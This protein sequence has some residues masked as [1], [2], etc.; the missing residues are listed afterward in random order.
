MA[1]GVIDD[2]IFFALSDGINS[3]TVWPIGVGEASGAMR[4]VQ[5]S[6]ASNS[7]NVTNA[8]IS[9]TQSGGWTV[10]SALDTTQGFHNADNRIKVS[11]ETGGSGLTDAELRATPVPIS[12][13]SSLLVSQLSGAVDSV[14]ITN[15]SIPVTGTFWQSTQPVSV[16]DTLVINQ[17]SGS[18]WSVSAS[19]DTTASLYNAD[20]R[21]RVSLEP[22]GSG[23]TDAE[24]RASPVPVMQVSGYSDSV[25]ITNASI[26]VTGTFWQT[27]QPISAGSSLTVDQLSGAN[28]SV[29]A[30]LVASSSINVNGA[31]NSTVSVGPV[32][33]DAVDDGAA[34]QKVGGTA[35]T[36]NPTAVAGGDIVRFVGDKIGRQLSRPVQ[37]REL[38]KTAYA[39]LT[40]GAET[41]LLAGTAGEFNDL[42]W[43]SFTNL[44]TAAVAL[45]T[46]A[47]VDIRSTTAGPVV[48]SAY[49][50]N[51][52]TVT[53]H[54]AV[55]IPM[56]T[57]ADA[58]TADRSDIGASANILVS[59]LF[60]REV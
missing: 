4:I 58:W 2:P 10:T 31:T 44:S 49:V 56:N 55:P 15:A 34:P 40:N 30:S 48:L 24:L 1:K 23:L 43:I 59:A 42:I 32:L 21:L 29:T 14:S 57:A 12:A 38:L 27:T 3:S 22:G 41:T 7:V 60:S 33:H 28:W 39:T 37:V 54:P 5:A 47:Q 26:P 18:N 20:N 36:A 16:T 46:G 51:K 35:M 11:V 53:I 8:S 25:N 9:V 13:G 17:V 19:L 50:E 52:A 6:D 45:N